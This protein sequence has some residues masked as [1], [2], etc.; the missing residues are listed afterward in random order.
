MYI[1]WIVLGIIVFLIII[2]FLM[3]IFL[4]HAMFSKRWEPDGI[5][6]YY[7]KEEYE[8]FNSEKVSFK[9]GKETLKGYI[10]SYP[11]KNYRGILVF[12][13]GMWGSHNAYLQEIEALAKMGFKVLGYDNIGTELSSGKNLKGLGSSLLGLDAAI[14]FIKK[15]YPNEEVFV[16]G[17]SWGGYAALGIA[18]Y[19]PDL[20]GIVAMSG[21]VSISRVLKSIL[22]RK[23]YFVIPFFIII[24]WFK[25]GR[26]SLSNNYK[27]LKKS[28]VKTLVIHSKD[29]KLV[30]FKL[31][32]GYLNKK[33]KN[34]VVSYL[35][36]DG[37]NH[38]PDYSD[39]AILYTNEVHMHLKELKGEEILNYKKEINYHKMGELDLEV[40]AKIGDFLN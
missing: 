19:H 1:L 16:M 18:K 3:A 2:M 26:Y 24:D 9:C 35:F 6:K 7:T 10:Y 15:T 12:A 29:D 27:V 22:P 37:K 4:H 39:E 14:A 8:N 34:P 21:F 32:P 11:L 31:N 28:N 20:K 33:L 40:I 5:V 13:H 36:V 25:C 38:N 30:K 23:M 17:H